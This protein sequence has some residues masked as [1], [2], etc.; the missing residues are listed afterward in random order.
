MLGHPS[1]GSFESAFPNDSSSPSGFYQ[2][3]L[4]PLVTRQICLELFGPE[5]R[6]RCGGRGKATPFV[7]VPETSMYE[8]RCMVAREDQ[9][10]M[11]WKPAVMKAVSEAPGMHCAS[12]QDFRFGILAPDSGHHPGARRG[13]DHVDHSFS[14]G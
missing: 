4:I 3:I 11:S 13:V 7:S 14:P 5:F 10:R 8:H 12:E 6:P 2:A 1:N 9:I